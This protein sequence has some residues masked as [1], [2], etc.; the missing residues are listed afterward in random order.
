MGFIVAALRL[1]STGSIVAAHELSCSMARG[2]FPDQGW[3]AMS[4]ALA[5]DSL[6]PEL[7]GS[8]KHYFLENSSMFLFPFKIL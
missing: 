8:P 2:V 1:Q 7:P 4:P 5:E 6:P 3:E